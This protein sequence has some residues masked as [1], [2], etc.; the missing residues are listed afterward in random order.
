MVEGLLGSSAMT[1][2]FH[3]PTDPLPRFLAIYDTA[4]DSGRWYE[5]QSNSLRHASLALTTVDGRPGELVRKMRS[6]ASELKS[7]SSAFSPMQSAMR[8]VF[9]S[10][11]VSLGIAPSRLLVEQERLRGYLR[12]ERLPRSTRA[13]VVITALVLM[14]QS[15]DQDGRP[16]ISREQVARMAQVYR[17]FKDDH[18]W[19]TGADDLAAAALLSE[20]GSHPR[21]VASHAEAI[22]Q[23]LRARR[24]SRGNALQMVSHLLCLHTDPADRVV[25]RFD[26]IYQAFKGRGLWMMETD[27]DEIAALC[28]T[29]VSASA[30]VERTLKLRQELRAK[31]YRLGKNESFS[32]AACLAMLDLLN[33]HRTAHDITAFTMIVR[34]Q[35]IVQAQQ[36]AVAASAAGGA[37][38]AS[39]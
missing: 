21:A 26:E 11:L 38:A 34:V 13:Y 39:G 17:A 3:L 16:R 27:Y 18:K 36:A 29:D 32:V 25:R 8:Y 4:R 7:A 31:N 22:Y 6:V 30:I 12:E 1:A 15:M 2:P 20:E 19:I 5:K 33:D 28:F 10:H 9:A 35:A 24:Y 14:E 23:G 37:A